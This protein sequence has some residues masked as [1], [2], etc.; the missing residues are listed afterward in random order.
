MC[1]CV[2]F[3]LYAFVGITFVGSRSDALAL[4][5]YKENYADFSG[6]KVRLNHWESLE[7]SRA[8]N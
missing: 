1:V 8:A 6:T 4:C 7:H 3:K 2:N 5:A